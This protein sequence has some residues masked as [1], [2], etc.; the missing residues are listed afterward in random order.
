MNEKH[1][2]GILG[3]L[4]RLP[5]EIVREAALKAAQAAWEA[6]CAERE[7]EVQKRRDMPRGGS[8]P[9]GAGRLETVHL[10]CRRQQ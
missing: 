5:S 8:Q 6:V 10:N 4:D 1:F 2:R 7:A 3:L 9:N